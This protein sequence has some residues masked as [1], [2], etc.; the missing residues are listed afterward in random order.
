MKTG[1]NRNTAHRV[2]YGPSRYGGLGFRDLFVEQGVAQVELL[3]RHLRTGTTQGTLM[4]IAISWWQM[5]VGVSYPLLGQTDKV[6]PFDAPHW[7]SSIRE[8]LQSVEA[9]IHIEG[10]TLHKPHHESDPCIMDVIRDLPGL[11]RPQLSAFY[12]CRVFLGVHFLS[13][14]VMADGRNLA[15]DTWEGNRE[16]ISTLLW[17]YQPLPGP[18]LFRT[19]RRLLAT[20]FLQGCRRR[21][22]HQT[23]DLTLRSSLGRWHPSSDN[24]RSHWSSFYAA[25]NNQLFLLSDDDAPTFNVY[26]SCPL[27]CRPVF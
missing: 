15:R 1:V 2:V 7:L 13:E 26:P 14:I 4:L 23:K 20:A 21:V 9:S 11:T 6:V 16:Q 3:V 24:F 10:L 17:P 5:V 8:F 12:R 25:S 27:R 18:T 19:W 22:S